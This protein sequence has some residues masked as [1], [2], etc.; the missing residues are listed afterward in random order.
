MTAEKADALGLEP[1]ARIVDTCL[2]GSD[3]VLMLDRP[4]PGHAAA[5]RRNGLTI[6]DIDLVEINE[7]FASVVLAWQRA[8]GADMEQVNPNGGAIA[9]GHPLG[10]TGAILLTKAVHEL[11]AHRQPARARH[12]VLRRRARHRHP[13]APR[14][15]KSAGSGRCG[16]PRANRGGRWAGSAA[17]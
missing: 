9:L 13:V 14:L 10:G 6:D 7:A 16:G 15:I 3:P 17:A 8:H 5:A 2:V 1:E 12:D 11:A 4:D